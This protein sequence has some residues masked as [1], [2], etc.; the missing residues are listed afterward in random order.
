MS[1]TPPFNTGSAVPS[2]YLFQLSA[3]PIKISGKV[4]C[5]SWILERRA[6]AVKLPR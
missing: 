4:D 2:W 1:L 6:S 5:M 3:V